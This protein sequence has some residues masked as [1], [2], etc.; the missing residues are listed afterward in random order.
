VSAIWTRPKDVELARNARSDYPK[1]DMAFLMPPELDPAAEQFAQ[2]STCFFSR[3]T[4]T[5]L[6]AIQLSIV[7]C[8]GPVAAMWPHEAS[9]PVP[10]CLAA[11][12]PLLAKAFHGVSNVRRSRKKRFLPSC[13]G[14]CLDFFKAACQK[15]LRR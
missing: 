15:S 7:D 9:E 6:K 3:P 4:D 11:L 14:R 2:T 12:L 5:E 1:P 8:L 13:P 10:K